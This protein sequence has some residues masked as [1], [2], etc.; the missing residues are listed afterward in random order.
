MPR[1]SAAS[2]P[3]AQAAAEH[4]LTMARFLVLPGAE[5]LLDAFSRIPPGPLREASI[6]QVEA[7][8]NAYSGAPPA[9]RMGDPLHLIA[10]P[11]SAR[12]PAVGAPASSLAQGKA[13]ARGPK[14]STPEGRALD[15]RFRGHNTTEIARKLGL[16]LR[17][18]QLILA[19]AR[20]EGT[21]F[22]PIPKDGRPRPRFAMSLDDL[23]PRGLSMVE[24]AAKMR[25]ITPEQYMER[26]RRAVDMAKAGIPRSEILK[27]TAEDEKTIAQWLTLAR[28]AGH[29]IPYE[30][31]PALVEPVKANGHAAAP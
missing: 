16:P 23:E 15:L 25:R 27:H 8:A 10:A 13:G 18:V 29:V 12:G 5:R 30:T 17:Q 1:K 14:L 2:P 24:K 9:H 6:A 4:L 19:K 7:I 21:Q 22:P 28:A 3:E 26:R 11:D 20:S 31:P